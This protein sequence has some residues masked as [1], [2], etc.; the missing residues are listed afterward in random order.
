MHVLIDGEMGLAFPEIKLKQ[1]LLTEILNQEEVLFAKTL[2]RGEALFDKIITAH[3]NRN[4]KILDGAD[5]WRLYDTFG[6]PID[7]TRLMAQENNY[8]VDEAQVLIEEKRAKEISKAGKSKNAID[9]VSLDV[10]ALSFL[11][12]NNITTTDDSL[13]YQLG[14]CTATVVAIFN[15]GFVDNIEGS[16]RFGV[17]LDKTNF[18]A[19]Q[20]G[21]EY[22]TGSIV[23]DDKTL[24]KVQEVQLFGKFVLH[25]GTL[26]YGSLSVSSK[27]ECIYDELRRWPIR[28]N[29]TG[30]HI[31][32]YALQS[33]VG[34]Q[35]DQKG[36]LVVPD[37]LRFDYSAN[38]LVFNLE[39]AIHPTSY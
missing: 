7:L 26:E 18:Y 9:N 11:E 30:T 24:F 13:K 36:S 10:H 35:V 23:I 4:V 2:D 37:K 33:V 8:E 27:V 14:N 19:E 38:V 3:A 29:H 22:D 31:L 34:G 25:I 5:V 17:L 32:N 16:S 39:W 1:A 28:N 21:Q 15:N 20:G 12:K 6:F